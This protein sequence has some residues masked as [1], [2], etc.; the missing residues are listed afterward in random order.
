MAKNN[1]VVSSDDEE[2]IL[3]DSADE[4]IGYASK[5]SCHDN[6]GK[7]HRA[8][9]IFVFN[10]KNEL[11]LQQ[12]SADKRLWP[13]YWANTCCSH[14]RKN[15]T[16]EFA[17]Q[18]RLQQEMGFECPLEFLY[19]FEYHELYHDLGAEHELCSVFVGYSE[20]P[21]VANEFEVEATRWVSPSAL[22]SEMEAHPER[23]T[24]WIKMEW[25]QLCDRLPALRQG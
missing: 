23:F 2:L 22:T 4:P 6:A 19:K 3:V 14:P 25:K 5:G 20:G 24:P 7:L 13:G 11:L 17:T 16:L 1:I 9:S 10:E 21:V 15:E 18:R 8:F 12:R